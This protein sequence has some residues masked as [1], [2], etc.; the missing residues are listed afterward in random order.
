MFTGLVMAVQIVF[1]VPRYGR[2][3]PCSYLSPSPSARLRRIV[4]IS[5]FFYRRCN[6]VLFTLGRFL[7]EK[8]ICGYT[9]LD[10]ENEDQLL[11][12]GDSKP[13]HGL[14]KDP[15]AGLRAILHASNLLT[16]RYEHCI[17]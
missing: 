1:Y 15:F 4:H 12:M 14:G 3:Q 6:L 10:E 17:E 7:T 5:G 13:A 9:Q 11:V 8:L 16:K 2:A